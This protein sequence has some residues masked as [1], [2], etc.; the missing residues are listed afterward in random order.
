VAAQTG[1]DVKGSGADIAGTRDQFQFAN[2]P[3]TGNFDI[4]VRVADLTITD[5][6]VKAGLMA[7]EN[8]TDSSRF[9]AVF[10]SSAQLGEF[11]ESRSA[12]ATAATL[13]GPRL[14]FPASYPWAWLRLSR[15]GDTFVGYGSFDGA[16]WQPLGTNT[17]VFTNLYFGMAVTSDATN[18]VATA[19]FRDLG[20]VTNPTA[21]TYKPERESIGPANR[22]TGIIFSEIMYHPKPRVDGRNMDF[23][24]IYNGEPIFIDMSGWKIAGGIDFTFPDGFKIGAGQFVVIAADPDAIQTNYGISEVMG[25]YLHS[26]SDTQDT[27]RLLNQAGAV[28]DELTYST[29]APWPPEADG[30]GHSLVCLRPS[31]GEDDPRAWGASQLIGGSPGYDDPIAPNPWKGVVINEFLAVPKS[32]DAAF[33]EL[34]NSSNSEVDLSGCFLTDS[35]SQ[36]KFRVPDA[37]RLPA[38]SWISFTTAQLGFNL[39]S[40][41]ST[42]YLISADQSRVL[43]CVRVD[44]QESGVS[45]GRAPDGSPVV[46]RLAT[47]SPGLE[48]STRRLEDIVINELMYNPVTGDADDEYIELYNRSAAAVNLGGWRFVSGID[49]TFAQGT[50]IPANGYVVVAK[51]VARMLANYPQL[52]ANNTFGDFGGQLKHGGERVALAKPGVNPNE[53]VTVSEVTYMSGGRWYDLANGGGS[54]LELKDPHADLLL[55]PNW[56][57]SDE[58][59]KSQWATY[60]QTATLSL[61]NQ[62]WPATKFFIMAQGAGEYLFDDIEVLRPGSTNVLNNGGLESGQTGWNFYGTHR[63]SAVRTTG[64]A[65]GNNCL[66]VNATEVGDEGPNS[67][68]GTLSVTAA[69]GVAY[70]IRAKIRWL[71]GW[72]E[73][74]LRIRGNG[75]EF[76]VTLNLPKNLGTPGLPN[77]RAVNNAGPAITDVTHYPTIP[78]ANEPV[79][80]TARVS[81]PDG[82]SAPQLVWRVDPATTTTSTPMHDDG[83]DGD[84][85]AGDGIYSATLP[86]RANGMVDFH[87]EAQDLAASSA[88]SAFPNDAPKREC[89]VRWGDAAP[90]GSFGH[91]HLWSTSAGPNPGQDRAYRD[92]SIIYDMR[93][94]Y[95]AGWRNKGS[96]FHSGIGSYSIGFPDDDLFLG[97]DKHVLR[98]TGNGGDE[99]TEMADDVAYWIGEKLGLPFNHARYVRVYRNGAL[100]YKI[101]YDLEVPDR[102]IAKDWFGGGGLA[103]TLYKIAGWFE[104]DDSDGG[105]TSSL[106]WAQMQNKPSTAPPFKMGAYRFNWQ[107]H[108]GGSTANDYRL[109]FNITAAANATDKITQLMNLADMEEWMRTLGHRRVISD[110]DSWSYNTGQNMYM[111][112]PLGER[113]KLM[114]W[115]MDFVLGL[116]DA[117]NAPLFSAGEDPTVQTLFSVPPYRRMLCRAYLDA[118]NGPLTKEVSDPQ[119]DS[120]RTI[121]SKNNITASTPAALKSFVSGRRSYILSQIKA[122]DAA[123]FTV[124]TQDFTT[125]TPTATITG[126]APF[127]VASIEVNGLPYPITWTTATGWSIKVPLG[128]AANVLQIVGKDLRGNVYAGATGKVTVTFTGAIPKAEDWVVINE[129]MYNA[130]LA[131]A[132]FIEIYNRHPSFAFDLS[133]YK[134]KGADFTFPGGTL[135]QPNGF[136]LVV[137]D[138]ASFASAYGLNIP[139]VGEYAGRLQNDGELLSLVKPGATSAQDVIVDE[140]HYENVF[141]W[142]PTADGFGP[143]LQRI[144]AAQDS[145][146]AGNWGVT[147]TN[148]VNRAT[149]GRANVNR[150][151]LDPFPSLWINE[152]VAVN[153]TGAKDSAGEHDPWIEIYNA[154]AQSVDLSLY[155]LSN[156]PNNP[157][158][159]QF[160]FGTTIGAGQFMVVWADGQTLQST[161]TELHTNFR[162][163]ATGG[164]IALSRIQLGAAANIDYAYY[165]ALGIDQSFGTIADGDTETRRLLFLPT[166]GGPNN[167][168]DLIVPVSINEWMPSNVKVLT[169]PADSNYDDWFELYNRGTNTVD[170]T[171]YFLS[172]SETNATKF[173]IPLGYTIPPQGFLLVWADDELTQNKSTNVDLHVNFKL[174]KTGD[175]IAL[176]TPNGAL[177]DSITFGALSDNISGGRYPDG[178]AGTFVFTTPTPRAANAAPTGT[179]FTRI[180]FDGA[181]ISIGWKTTVGR[182]YRLEYATDLNQPAWTAA[183]ADVTATTTTS[184]IN[185][186]FA[187]GANRYYRVVQVN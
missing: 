79:V 172:D 120:R 40:A 121:L 101:D 123:A 67:V 89:L 94:I 28:R 133:G 17:I 184:T 65:S 61:A 8:L 111:Y 167:P 152:I 134:L 105:G 160:P 124:T 140:V 128:A 6:Y 180:A 138:S 19:K 33:I 141:P 53:F 118:A 183:G 9:A 24:E 46:R 38:R 157:L 159:W 64:A 112:A 92:C 81:D 125:A 23:V 154:G 35:P 166:P 34:Y 179:R 95:N 18:A 98:S 13:T 169:D 185:V 15:S 155:Y 82:F 181:Q 21:F 74:L 12:S 107:S 116:G 11:F 48:N 2:K 20:D 3:M 178:A 80:V 135:I 145:W 143:S 171:G 146:R 163:S 176:F 57:A 39:S 114:S 173:Q 69:S 108:P 14:K 54:S 136:S 162:L 30:A 149:P 90:F 150:A 174:A 63:S 186:D 156:D 26:L 148:D 83:L 43:D 106:I 97:S 52:N 7:R 122:I 45:M 87:V 68:R 102:S 104:Y 91:Y 110:W 126:L 137:K 10:A 60:E 113:A 84:E 164:I 177:L 51:N 37:T 77:S 109:L 71:S 59:Q 5:A 144:D 170:L 50:S 85:L 49:F 32:T 99:G 153:Q 72:P 55:A 187:A 31:Y 130:S 119:F 161:A 73:I 29:D 1:Y 147:G 93:T 44:G 158:L 131:N 56:A 175:A 76:P 27:L 41:G 129:I 62:G 115:D 117:S 58:T 182:T 100:H 142:P 75:I 78:G 88:S 42:F 16:A 168:G 66:Y 70:T 127:N 25:P 96:P 132:E 151:T 165:P 139:I 4:R 86:G 36:N 22:R 47:P 103:D